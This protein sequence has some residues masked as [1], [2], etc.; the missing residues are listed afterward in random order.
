MGNPTGS[1]STVKTNPEPKKGDASDKFLHQLLENP[2]AKEFNEKAK[3]AEADK[4]NGLP[5]DWEALSG[6]GEQQKTELQGLLKE[7][8]DKFVAA[9]KDVQD[10]QAGDGDKKAGIFKDTVNSDKSVDRT[11]TAK[12]QDGT[13]QSKD[14][15]FK[16]RFN[17]DGSVDL[18]LPEGHPLRSLMKDGTTIRFKPN[19]G[20]DAA[21]KPFTIDGVYDASGKKV[22]LD[23][24]QQKAL[25]DGVKGAAAKGNL[26]ISGKGD[27]GTEWTY[28]LTTG[29]T[30]V[31]SNIPDH[32]TLTLYPPNSAGG[33][34]LKGH[35]E[36]QGNKPGWSVQM[37]GNLRYVDFDDD[38][39]SNAAKPKDKDGN[40]IEGVVWQQNGEPILNISQTR[41]GEPE[42]AARKLNP[43]GS[44]ETTFKPNSELKEKET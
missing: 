38:D 30:T 16:Q 42:I 2:F 17:Q 12:F 25:E 36:A 7:P 5:K 10:Q 34:D 24:T 31:K 8:M 18:T 29:N 14:G 43:D 33:L 3:P 6:Q 4:K 35:V 26:S 27:K 44:T 13:G 39:R 19:T 20:P 9:S 23:A 41:A 37:N 11:F 32:A 21:D 40:R 22:S 28:D 15:N 1:D